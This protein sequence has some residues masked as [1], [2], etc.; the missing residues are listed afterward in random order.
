MDSDGWH[1]VSSDDDLWV[2]DP[3]GEIRILRPGEFFE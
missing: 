2:L 1:I 3:W